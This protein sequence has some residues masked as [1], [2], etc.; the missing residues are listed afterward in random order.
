MLTLCVATT[1]FPRWEGDYRGTFIWEACRALSTLGTHVLVVAPHAEGAK[2]HEDIAGVEIFRPRYL[3]P[4]RWEILLDTPGGLPVVWEKGGPGRLI[5]LPLL[6]AHALAIARIARRCDLIHANWTFS[7]FAAGLTEPIHR[8]PIVCTVQGSDIYRA[9]RIPFAAGLARRTLRSAR[10]VIALSASLAEGAA[11]LGVDPDRIAV[12]PNGVDAARFH[13][14]GTPREPV[15]LFAGS[16]IQRK[17]LNALLHAM[18]LIHRRHPA[19]HLVLIGDGPKRAELE[20]QS[21]ALGIGEA[22]YFTGSLSPEEVARWM[23]RAE[24]F[25]LPSL[26]EGQGV[27]LLEALASGTPCVG[28]RAGGIPEVL[29]PQWGEL[30]EPGNPEALADCILGLID[31][32]SSRQA[33]GRAAAAGVRAVYDWPVVAR[34][35]LDV[36]REALEVP[37]PVLRQVGNSGQV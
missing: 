37:T 14:N 12:I 35:I 18:A 1:S 19:H 25:V 30:V 23:R 16:L 29:S 7:A 31:S 4:E 3:R 27:A 5:V 10:R 15:L 21:R 9:A 2:T 36:Y 22:V 8:R 34:R 26:E 17:G 28:S 6:A 32:P 11:A 33:M 20:T 13:P 24:L